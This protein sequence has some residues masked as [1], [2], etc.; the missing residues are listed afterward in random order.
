[1]NKYLKFS[2]IT[3]IILLID[4]ISKIYLTTTVNYGAAFGIL[5]G[6]TTFLVIISII[7]IIA[8]LYY[9]TKL[10]G[11]LIETGMAILLAGIIGNLI[12]RIV[13]GYVRD[14]ISIW[15]WPAFNIADTANCI[16]VF[17]IIIWLW[18]TNSTEQQSF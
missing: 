12:D 11:T 5:Q 17:L 16:G 8:I 6:A 9:I 18:K 3:I 7:A 15:I 10:K 14:F 13:L 4:Q 2:L 1:M